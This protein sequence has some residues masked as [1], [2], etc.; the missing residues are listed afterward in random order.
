MFTQRHRHR[1]KPSVQTTPDITKT[2]S[3]PTLQFQPRKS[4][5]TSPESFKQFRFLPPIVDTTFVR[6]NTS[7]CLP[8]SLVTFCNVN[9]CTQLPCCSVCGPRTTH[10][11]RG[12]RDIL[13]RTCTPQPEQGRV[14][15]PQRDHAAHEVT[16]AEPTQ[17]R[18][19]NVL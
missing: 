6:H 8:A 3:K 9:V 11:P 1:H 10:L 5:F 4:Y 2:L 12:E 19:F 13:L 17:R 18:T 16:S 7:T 14:Q 15:G